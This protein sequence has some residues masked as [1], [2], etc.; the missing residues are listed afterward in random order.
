MT[1]P[2]CRR[3]LRLRWRAL[4]VLERIGTKEAT[5]LLEKLA[6]G[7]ANAQLTLEAK[8]SLDRLGTTK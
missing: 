5:A 1:A 8:A 3:S 4:V 2:P 7:D 6:A